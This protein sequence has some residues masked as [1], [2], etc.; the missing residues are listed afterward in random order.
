MLNFD[1]KVTAPLLVKVGR[2]FAKASFRPVINNHKN[3]ILLPLFLCLRNSECKSA[4]VFA[5]LG[6]FFGIGQYF[7][8]I[9]PS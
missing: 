1:K 2:E 4:W 8:K 7:F 9:Q 6:F 5:C 3:E